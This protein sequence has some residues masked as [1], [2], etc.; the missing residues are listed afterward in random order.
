MIISLARTFKASITAE[1]VKQR[2]DGVSEVQFDEIQ[3]N[4]YSK[5]LPAALKIP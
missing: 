2:T 5:P 1:G 3:G 4:Y